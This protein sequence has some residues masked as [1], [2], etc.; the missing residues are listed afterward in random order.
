MKSGIGRFC[1]LMNYF[2]VQGIVWIFDPVRWTVF[3]VQVT[4]E[5]KETIYGAYSFEYFEIIYKHYKF[6]IF[7]KRSYIITK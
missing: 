5:I 6:S 1:P 3:Q 2:S 4:E 7:H